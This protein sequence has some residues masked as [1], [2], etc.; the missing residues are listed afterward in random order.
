MERY[1]LAPPHRAPA[2]PARHEVPLLYT[3]N[4]DMFQE[5][6]HILSTQTEKADNL[7]SKAISK[8]KF[9]ILFVVGSLRFSSWITGMQSMRCELNSTG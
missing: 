5:E 4:S 3:Y 8:W 9:D 1:S 6:A 2:V 7:E